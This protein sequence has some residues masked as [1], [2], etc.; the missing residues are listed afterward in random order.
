MFWVEWVSIL[1]FA[2][3]VIYVI[4][5]YNGDE[6]I[7]FFTV[8]TPI[9]LL[10]VFN[11][12]MMLEVKHVGAIYPIFI[13]QG[14]IAIVALIFAIKL[15]W[16]HVSDISAIKN[17]PMFL[18]TIT[19]INLHKDYTVIYICADG[20]ALCSEFSDAFLDIKNE[21]HEKIEPYQSVY[22]VAEKWKEE[23]AQNYVS[24]HLIP[25][26][27]VMAKI[28]KEYNPMN[29][30]SIKTFTKTLAKHTGHKKYIYKKTFYKPAE[31]Y[32]G[33]PT[34]GYIHN[35][36]I[37]LTGG[38]STIPSEKHTIYVMGEVFKKNQKKQNTAIN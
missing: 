16:N 17:N 7:N 22:K 3:I 30:Y 20:I 5:L 33:P 12:L 29:F 25:E 13:Y 38:S 15:I 4:R 23:C 19:L 6:D 26:K 31:T 36:R 1:L 14:S 32:S 24:V 27:I 21:Y 9:G 18:E 37:T 28:T 11:Y 10:L 35:G 34:G 8:L 2:F